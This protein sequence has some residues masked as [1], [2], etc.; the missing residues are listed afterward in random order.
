MEVEKIRD[1]GVHK[2]EKGN[3]L[4]IYVWVS[5]FY[6]RTHLSVHEVE[7]RHGLHTELHGV[8]LG[9]VLGVVGTVEVVAR[10]ARLAA[11]HVT[12]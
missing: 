8:G 7:G 9:K 11:G 6:D 10:D 4:S 3:G 12:A 2:V 5:R 1:L